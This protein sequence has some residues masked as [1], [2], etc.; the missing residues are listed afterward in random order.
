MSSPEAEVTVLW[1]RTSRRVMLIGQLCGVLIGGFGV[2]GAAAQH[3]ISRQIFW[4]NLTVIGAVIAGCAQAFWLLE[5]RR[6]VSLL[7]RRAVTHLR[8]AATAPLTAPSVTTRLGAVV[9]AGG[10]SYHAPDCVLVQGKPLLPFEGDHSFRR[11]S[12]CAS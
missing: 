12:V 10:R 1:S 5:G 8:D 2:A 6:S 7:R 11:C 9:V 4:I 3:S